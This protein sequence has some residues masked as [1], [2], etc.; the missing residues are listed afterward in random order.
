MQ[1]RVEAFYQGPLFQVAPRR[2]PRAVAPGG[3]H[4]SPATHAILTLLKA[5]ESVFQTFLLTK[6]WFM[7]IAERNH[8][9]MQYFGVKTLSETPFSP[10]L[11]KAGYGARLDSSAPRQQARWVLARTWV[12][13]AV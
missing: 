4:P 10:P 1:I 6:Q 9:F 2:T 5:G 11:I 12:R 7:H 13:A 8:C 3:V